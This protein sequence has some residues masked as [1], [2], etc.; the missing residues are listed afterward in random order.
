MRVS[1]KKRPR[2]LALGVQRQSLSFS[3]KGYGGRGGGGVLLGFFPRR[4]GVNRANDAPVPCGLR[5]F[6]AVQ[7]LLLYESAL[8]WLES[9]LRQPNRLT[10]LSS[11][12]CIVIRASR[13]AQLR[14]RKIG[15]IDYISPCRTFSKHVKACRALLDR[16]ASPHNQRMCHYRG[17][18]GVSDKACHDST[19]GVHHSFP[20]DFESLKELSRHLTK[21]TCFLSKHIT[22]E[23][24][25]LGVQN[26]S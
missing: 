17:I 16:G 12:R 10:L 6:R 24:H 26:P 3:R 13:I 21:Q 22:K 14:Q 19:R 1:M 25:G 2:H 18:F 8:G 15:T 5:R 11:V 7:I 23:T 4:L 20:K 9:T